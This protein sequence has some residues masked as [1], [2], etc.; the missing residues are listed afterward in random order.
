MEQL[1]ELLREYAQSIRR[2]DGTAFIHADAIRALFARASSPNAAG[3]DS[4]TDRTL[5]ETIGERD[6]MEEI[7]TRLADA[8]GEFLGIDVGEWSSANNPILAAIE[9]LRESRAPRTDVAGGMVIPSGFVLVEEV[10]LVPHVHPQYGPGVFCTEDCMNKPA[11]ATSADAVAAPT[12]TRELPMM[13]KAFRVTEV[14]GDP[15]PAKQSFVM[16]FSFPSIDALHAADDEWNK[17][18]AA[19]P[20]D[21]QAVEVVAT[22][23]VIHQVWVEATSSWVDVTPAYYAER[24]PSNRRRVYYAPPPPAPASAPVGLTSEQRENVDTALTYLHGCGGFEP[25]VEL[26][27]ELLKGDKQ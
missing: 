4:D 16:R 2:D 22:G 3:V 25:E 5:S 20:T 7:G 27:R 24:Q 26:L 18:T 8:V 14:S 10:D 19:A 12:E 21:V 13:R 17:F 15:D 9:A 11:T 1:N 6:Q 23:Q